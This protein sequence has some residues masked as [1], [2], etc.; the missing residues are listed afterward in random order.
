MDEPEVPNPRWE[1]ATALLV[2][3]VQRG[4]DDAKHYGRRNNPDCE[5]HIGML[6]DA[7]RDQRWPVVFVQYDSQDENSPLYPGTQGHH[8]K[9]VSAGERDLHVR[10]SASSAFVGHPDLHEHLYTWVE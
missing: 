8:F 10:K 3:D 4:L 1:G 2:V 6:L 9:T 7:W 5:L